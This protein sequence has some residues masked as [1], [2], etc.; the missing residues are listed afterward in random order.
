[1]PD[2]VR[3]V[4]ELT[5]HLASCLRGK[6][7][8]IGLQFNVLNWVESCNKHKEQKNDSKTSAAWRAS[9]K[10]AKPTI[11]QLSPGG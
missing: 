11:V 5:G 1:V 10:N 8:D 7:S 6:A 4:I 3:H 9:Q 2:H